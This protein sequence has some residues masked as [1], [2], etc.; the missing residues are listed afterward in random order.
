MRFFIKN[1]DGNY[2]RTI[3]EFTKSRPNLTIVETSV[4][5]SKP[6]E[7]II[8]AKMSKNELDDFISKLETGAVQFQ[9]YK[10]DGT[11]R[12]ACGTRMSEL[13]SPEDID[14]LGQALAQEK[15]K[16]LIPY[17]DFQKKELRQFHVSRFVKT[18]QSVPVVSSQISNVKQAISSGKFSN[19][20]QLRNPSIADIL[21]TADIP[22]GPRIS[23][24]GRTET[25]N[26]IREILTRNFTASPSKID[27]VVQEIMS[28]VFG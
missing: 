4:S 6:A 12:N 9:Y 22:N 14:L 23:N 13:M 17:Y 16:F 10:K 28:E 8:E 27:A 2:H 18:V 3:S 20:D 11:L 19:F 25:E 1:F 21:D 15:S 26:A 7:L 5:D 24:N